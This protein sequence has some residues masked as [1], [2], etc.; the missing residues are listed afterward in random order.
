[1]AELFRLVKYYNLPRYMLTFGV[2]IDGKC[3]H[4]YIYIY[5]IHGSYGVYSSNSHV[6]Y[7][8]LHD[9]VIFRANV[10]KYSMELLG[11]SS[12]SQRLGLTFGFNVWVYADMPFRLINC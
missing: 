5:S 6:W 12:N 7:V 4:I 10:G 1:M 9:W 11:S 3:D 8:Y 2:Y